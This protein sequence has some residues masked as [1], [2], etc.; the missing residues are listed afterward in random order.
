MPGARFELHGFDDAGRFGAALARIERAGVTR[1]VSCD[2]V[3]HPSN[4]IRVEPLVARALMRRSGE[5]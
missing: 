4:A 3:V 5:D 2:T 1:V